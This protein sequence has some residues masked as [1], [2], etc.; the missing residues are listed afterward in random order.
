M[1]AEQIY[2][3]VM[4]LVGSVDP[5]GDS[6]IDSQRYGNL[7]LLEDVTN[8]LIDHILDLI[9]NKDSYEGSVHDVGEEAQKW[10]LFWEEE[11]KYAAR[12]E[13]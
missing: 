12:G 5:V 7:L 2:E 1:D 10:A 11:L 8:N 3:V 6:V 4:K 9:P 13:E